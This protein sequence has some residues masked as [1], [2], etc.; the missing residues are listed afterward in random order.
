MTRIDRCVENDMTHDSAQ[1]IFDNSSSRWARN[2]P[3]L[4][5]DW[6]ARPFLLQWCLPVSGQKVLD[7]GCG[8]GY[9][10]R[11]L[12][13]Q[14]AGDVSGFDIS[15][16]MIELANAEEERDPL[17]I[18]YSV[19]CATGFES[20]V[21][22]HYDLVTAV[23]VYNYVTIAD[24]RNSMKK[25]YE[26]LSVGGRFVFSLPHP[27]NPF[28]AAED[29]R[30]HFE[31]VGGWFSG[32][33]ESFAGR[34]AQRDGS[35]VTVRC[36]HK[37]FEDVLHGLQNAGFTKFPDF[38]ELGVTQEHIDIDAAFFQPLHDQPLHIAFRIEK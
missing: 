15:P 11:Q 23:F 22:P 20:S 29:S 8:E 5:S 38:K 1:E 4:L 7:M 13:R 17:G 25:V 12:A 28:I 36:M 32:R 16:G 10:T 2:E 24:M 37:T 18:T 33:D 6:T 19:G 30:F 35:E 14:G 21:K 3:R 27:A 9:F 31:R 34:M 26:A